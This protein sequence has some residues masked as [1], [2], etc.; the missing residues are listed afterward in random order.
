MQ[1]IAAMQDHHPALTPAPGSQAGLHDSYVDRPSHTGI[2]I[3]S[4]VLQDGV[5][6]SGNEDRRRRNVFVLKSDEMS[7]GVRCTLKMDG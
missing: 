3:T 7:V 2:V 5:G 6:G 1:A 4:L